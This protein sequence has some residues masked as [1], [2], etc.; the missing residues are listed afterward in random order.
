MGACLT[1]QTEIA[2]PDVCDCD[3]SS[4][5]ADKKE[6]RKALSS[7]LHKFKLE[8]VIS[9]VMEYLPDQFTIV[10]LAPTKQSSDKDYHSYSYQC[11]SNIIQQNIPP[12]SAKDMY[13][14]CDK[15]IL[16]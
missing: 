14:V 1:T 2:V 16:V 3:L 15:H 10:N 8:Y 7:V 11:L 5:G 6:T 12:C 9:I 4:I 13:K